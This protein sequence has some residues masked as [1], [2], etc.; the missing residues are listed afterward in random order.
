MPLDLPVAHRTLPNGLQVVV[1]EDHAVPSVSMSLWVDVGSRH[2]EPGRTGLAHLFEH[3]M[4]QGSELVAEGEHMATLMAHGG[5]ANASTNFDRTAYVQSVPS[6]CLELALWLEAD[7]HGHLLPALTQEN[8]DNQRDVV[9]EEKRQRYDTVPYGTALA[10][11]CDMLFPPDHPY[12]HPT[13]GSM[14]DLAAATLQDA[15]DF[16]RSHYGPRTSVLTLVGDIGPE[17]GFEL[18]ERYFGHLTD[19]TTPRPAPT[20]ALPPLEQPVRRVVTDPQAPSER[21]YI[22]ARLPAATDPGFLPC[23]LAL[24]AIASLG[25]SLVHERLLR[26]AESASGASAS[27]LG[28]RDGTSVGLI[29]ADVTE[30]TDPREVEQEIAQ[31]LEEFAADGPRPVELEASRADSERSWS[32]ALAGYDE[33]ADLLSRATLLFADPAQVTR[34]LDEVLAVGADEIRDAAARHL[35]PSALATLVYRWE[36]EV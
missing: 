36:P 20:A 33:R 21:L 9:V 29:V 22:A 11:L 3:L 35:V 17:E 8:L 26:G 23:A 2:E 30:G 1:S 13:I 34:H 4:F 31:I 5:R 25:I 18:V 10:A 27:V 19:G 15:H 12:A 24:D 16:Y 7:R 32:E 6:S 14:D 28:L